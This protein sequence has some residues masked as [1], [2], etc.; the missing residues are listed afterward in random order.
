MEI[1][2]QIGTNAG[3]EMEFLKKMLIVD[4]LSRKA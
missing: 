2:S 3:K 1:N 4:S